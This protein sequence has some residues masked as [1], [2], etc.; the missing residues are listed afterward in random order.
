[1][2]KY[3]SM[4]SIRPIT[5]YLHNVYFSVSVKIKEGAEVHILND[6]KKWILSFVDIR[7]ENFNT[8]PHL[9]K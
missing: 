1:M 8:H 9:Y 2:C 7:T 3:T 6:C 4:N 5:F